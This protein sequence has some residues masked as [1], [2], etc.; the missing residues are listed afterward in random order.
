MRLL[1][2][3]VVDMPAVV[4]AEV[5]KAEAPA[6]LPTVKANKRTRGFIIMFERLL[7]RFYG[8]ATELMERIYG[9]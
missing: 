2:D 7:L 5:A 3:V 6:T 9:E 1:V 4:L 8:T